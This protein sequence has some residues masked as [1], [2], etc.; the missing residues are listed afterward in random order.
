M[1]A[2]PGL[3]GQSRPGG[4][5]VAEPDATTPLINAATP[6][7]FTL[8]Q[9]LTVLDVRGDVPPVPVRSL[10][11]P[12]GG[13]LGA[14]QLGQ[15]IVLAERLTPG[16][17]VHSLHTVFSRPGDCELPVWIDVEHLAHGRSVGA[18]ALS[19]RQH[20]Q[21]LSRTNIMLRAPEPDLGRFTPTTVMP[22]G[23][24]TAVGLPIRLVPWE[25]RL[26]PQRAEFQLEH[27]VRAADAGDDPTLWRAL[28]AHACEF[29][30]LDDIARLSGMVTP[31]GEIM[32]DST[33]L[34]LSITVTYFA[35]LDVREWLLY[36]VS[37]LSIAGG[38]TTSRV[39][40]LTRAGELRAEASVVG[41]LRRRH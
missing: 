35:E 28:I 34:V 5:A 40:I 1:V 23:P 10:R 3:T 36:R 2:Q 9:L 25:T 18:L 31:T 33:A 38:R 39:E 17:T 26:L 11:S 19:V 4:R 14:Q 41:I 20:S 29:M 24:E 27:W 21:A 30:P 37:A 22:A 13:V 32:P 6:G 12:H 7:R 15:Q 16:K 8:A